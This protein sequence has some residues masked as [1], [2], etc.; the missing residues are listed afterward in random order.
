[1]SAHALQRDITIA[2]GGPDCKGNWAGKKRISRSSTNEKN[3][4]VEEKLI[5]CSLRDFDPDQLLH[6]EQEII[7]D[8]FR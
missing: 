5:I 7:G 1:M 6:L 8:A 2:K 4:E 3:V